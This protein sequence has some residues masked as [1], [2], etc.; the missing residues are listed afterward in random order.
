MDL[1]DAYEKV[2]NFGYKHLAD[3]CWGTG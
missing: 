1:N 2:Y 3:D